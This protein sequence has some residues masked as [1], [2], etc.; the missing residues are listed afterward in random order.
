MRRTAIARDTR[1][2]IVRCLS[3]I[4]PIGS[5]G[6]HGTWN[7]VTP[8]GSAWTLLDALVKPVR[9]IGAGHGIHMGTAERQQDSVVQVAHHRL[10][11]G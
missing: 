9:D 6:E 4:A 11:C 7:L 2:G 5:V 8:S 1:M 10:F 3:A